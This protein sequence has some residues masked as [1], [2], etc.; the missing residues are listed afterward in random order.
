MVRSNS[1]H[2]IGFR[3]WLCLLTR[4]PAA[5]SMMEVVNMLT[6]PHMLPT[7]APKPAPALMC[8]ITG[9]PARYRDP[10]S[11]HGYAD[12][13]AY[14]ELKER[15]NSERRGKTGKRTK[16]QRSSGLMQ[17]TQPLASLGAQPVTE[18]VFGQTPQH[19]TAEAVATASGA[20]QAAVGEVQPGLLAPNAN[21]AVDVTAKSP[22]EEQ[23]SAVQS[24]S[25]QPVGT[26]KATS[27]TGA[28]GVPPSSRTV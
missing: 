12:L 5:Q 3:V 23:G 2:V 22:C 18:F 26:T 1:I 19:A 27:M 7:K 24:M 17:T 16:R 4:L 10:A 11:G 6:P 8:V 9:K 28:A 15:W 20:M 25:M 21:A 14:Q 13:A